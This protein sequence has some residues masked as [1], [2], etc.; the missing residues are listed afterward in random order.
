MLIWGKNTHTHKKN[1]LNTG[2]VLEENKELLNIFQCDNNL[3][4]YLLDEY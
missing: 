1:P 3:N 4:S 2:C